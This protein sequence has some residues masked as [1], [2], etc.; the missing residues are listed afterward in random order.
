MAMPTEHHTKRVR[1]HAEAVEAIRQALSTIES[2]NRQPDDW[3][4]VNLIAVLDLV[5]RGAYLFVSPMVAHAM[6]PADKRVKI[7]ADPAFNS[8]DLDFFRR[9]LAETA[10]QPVRD[11]ATVAPWHKD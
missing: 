1:E 10:A 5:L 6:T 2:Q 11:H 7:A 3:E 8:C 9:A 4:R